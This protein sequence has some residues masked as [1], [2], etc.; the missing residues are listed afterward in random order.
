MSTKVTQHKANAVQLDEFTASQIKA[1]WMCV[2]LSKMAKELR[3]VALTLKWEHDYPV[4]YALSDVRVAVAL[5]MSR[6]EA[7]GVDFRPIF[8]IIQFIQGD[9]RASLIA[10]CFYAADEL[11][12]AKERIAKK[13]MA[14]TVEGPTKRTVDPHD[15]LPYLGLSTANYTLDSEGME[16]IKDLLRGTGGA[17][18]RRPDYFKAHY[19]TSFGQGC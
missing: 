19:M 17:I 5:G 1:H 2:A 10:S 14:R 11:V 6:C 15:G 7:H 9:T 4:R 18:R 3:K 13:G 12:S 8:E 16:A